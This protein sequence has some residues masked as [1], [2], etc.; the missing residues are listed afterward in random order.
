MMYWT[1]WGTSPKIEQAEMDGSMRRTIVTENLAWPN[2]LTVDLTTN[3]LFWT[4]ALLDKIEVSDLNGRNRQLI[5][6][7]TANIHPFG[8]AV[9]QDMLYWTDWNTKSISRFNLSSGKQEMIV[10]G[11]KKPTDIHVFDPSLIFSGRPTSV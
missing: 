11:L 8:L 7:A 9:Y 6:P 3:R 4:D 10:Y 5:M 1:D 2:G